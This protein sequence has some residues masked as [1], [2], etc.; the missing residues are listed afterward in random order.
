M[1]QSATQRFLPSSHSWSSSPEASADQCVSTI[2]GGKTLTIA[3][4]DSRSLTREGLMRLLDRSERLNLIPVSLCSELLSKAPEVLSRVEIVLLNLGS[5]AIGDPEIVKDI[6]L[7]N[8]TLPNAS[9]IVIGDRDDGHHVGEALRQGIRGYIPTNLTS[10]ILMGALRLVQ[11]GGTFVPA[12][13]LT[14]ALSQ[15]PLALDTAKADAG[16]LDLCGLT[17]RQR[18]VFDLLRQGKPNKI[19][20][21]ELD[22]RESTVKVH[23]RQIMRKMRVSNRTEAAFLASNFSEKKRA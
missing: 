8:E 19:I 4:I 11:S 23:V 7:L 15:Q 17:P 20:A 5:T 12:G 1:T 18:E 16:P 10:Q 13:A 21:H 6:G 14:D 3:L 9:I 22:M 2:T